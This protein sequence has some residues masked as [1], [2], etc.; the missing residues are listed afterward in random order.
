MRTP[1]TPYEILVRASAASLSELVRQAKPVG[2]AAHRGLATMCRS[3]GR[4][5]LVL[6][7]P[8]TPAGVVQ[9]EVRHEHEGIPWTLRRTQ[10]QPIRLITAHL[11]QALGTPQRPHLELLVVGENELWAAY[12]SES[13]VPVYDITIKTV[14]DGRV[15][16]VP[17][18]S[19]ERANQPLPRI[20]L[21]LGSQHAE[22]RWCELHVAIIGAGRSGSLVA[23]GLSSQGV[24]KITLIDPDLIES[25]NL[26]GM[27]LVGAGDVGRPKGEAV[28]RELV[29]RFPDLAVSALRAE[30]PTAEAIRLIAPADIVVTTTD[31]DEPRM[32]AAAITRRLV[33]VHVDIGTSS[34]RWS[35]SSGADIR[36][37][38]PGGRCLLCMGGIASAGAGHGRP[39]IRR[40]GTSSRLI[41]ATAAH[42][43]IDMLAGSFAGASIQSRW[44][45]LELRGTD[46]SLTTRKMLPADAQQ[47]PCPWCGG[48]QSHISSRDL[49]LM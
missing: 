23:D 16:T 18:H 39:Q 47:V 6:Q 44:A 35:G 28:G 45:R 26:D 3:E 9:A 7:P 41:N 14:P 5:I 24:R 40:P 13:G 2:F 1:S 4:A 33:Q 49:Q 10:R 32:M 21:R 19:V 25:G 22:Q 31:A 48:S 27:A 11:E 15:W 37:C 38:M 43:A 36:M 12:W 8:L 17:Y 20:G 42:L 34:E 46:H 29:R 30:F